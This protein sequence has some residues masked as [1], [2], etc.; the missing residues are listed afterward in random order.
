MNMN[1]IDHQRLIYFQLIIYLTLY[2]LITYLTPSDVRALEVS[3]EKQV[4]VERHV[5]AGVV[6]AH[7]H[8]ELLFAQDEPVAHPERAVPHRARVVA[9]GQREDGLHVARVQAVRAALHRP[10]GD[11]REAVVRHGRAAHHPAA[12][13]DGEDEGDA[14]ADGLLAVEDGALADEELLL[15]VHPPRDDRAAVQVDRARRVVAAVEH[16]HGG[17]HVGSGEWSGRGADDPDSG[18]SEER[19]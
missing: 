12:A 2:H 8:V 19:N 9:V 14:A 7:V 11:A 15:V 10:A 3:V 13:E 6:H 18:G 1:E 17:R 5:L 4:E 16:H